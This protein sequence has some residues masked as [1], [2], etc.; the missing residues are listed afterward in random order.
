MPGPGVGTGGRQSFFGK[1]R[2]VV[3]VDQV[4]RDARMLRAFLEQGLQDFAAFA[5][6]GKSTIGLGR[7][8]GQGERVKDGSFVIIGIGSLKVSHLP[9]EDARVGRAVPLILTVD[10]A[11]RVNVAF[12]ASRRF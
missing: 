6:V 7:S 11:Q 8:N 3:T 5:L 2:V 1:R 9:F 4:V 12:L 10:L